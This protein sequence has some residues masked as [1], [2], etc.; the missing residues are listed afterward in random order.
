MV[1]FRIDG[2][3]LSDLTDPQAPRPLVDCLSPDLPGP[4]GRRRGWSP[5][6]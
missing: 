3:Q 4:R 1:D 5:Y 2:M 6:C